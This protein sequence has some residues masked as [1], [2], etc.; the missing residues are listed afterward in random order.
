MKMINFAKSRAAFTI[1]AVMAAF[2]LL[3]GTASPA[4]AAGTA[5][6]KEDKKQETAATAE[7]EGFDTPA[8]AILAYA[9]AL[10]E[11]DVEKMISTFAVE[12]LVEKFDPMYYIARTRALIPGSYTNMYYPYP[13]GTVY[14]SANIEKRRSL[15]VQQIQYELFVITLAQQGF[16][17]DADTS[18]DMPEALRS[19]YE[20][21]TYT[22]GNDKEGV[23]EAEKFIEVFSTVPD[24]SDMEIGEVIYAEGL[25]EQYSRFAN[26]QN[27]Y[28]TA[29]MYGGDGIRSL[30]VHLTIEGK[31]ALLF[32]DTIKYGDKWYNFNQMGNLA[33]LLGINS[34]SGGLAVF[35]KDSDDWDEAFAEYEADLKAFKEYM[36]KDL[37]DEW[38]E[39]R[40]EFMEETEGMTEEE[41]EK[42]LEEQKKESLKAHLVSPLYMTFEEI[43]EFFDLASL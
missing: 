4:A 30:A 27:M 42:E 41:I 33:M 34:T 43:A 20:G 36:K 40:D 37:P 11:G 35:G 16:F 19:L 1:F 8:E 29:K 21:K 6:K 26:A 32:M 22:F 17:Y 18:S 14:Q 15:I 5:D 25:N 28:N 31:E 38:N 3:I 2:I 9:E 13:E 23:E 7:G 12:S 39:Q 10:K 24:L